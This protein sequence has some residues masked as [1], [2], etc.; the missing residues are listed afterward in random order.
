MT[1][2]RY[3][4]SEKRDKIT[5]IQDLLIDRYIEQKEAIEQGDRSRAIELRFE[6]KELQHEIEKIR[7]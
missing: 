1:R 4:T 7:E 5:E 2:N 3:L 6:N